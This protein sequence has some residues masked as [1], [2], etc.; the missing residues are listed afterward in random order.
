MAKPDRLKLWQVTRLARIQAFREEEASR[1]LTA[2]RQQLAQA[3][4][5][6]ADAAAAYEKDVAEQAIARHQR[7]Q[8][9]VGRELNGATVRALHA[10]DNAGL[11][12]IKQHAATYKKAGQHTEQA[13]S[14][15]KNAEHA[16]AHARKTT[17][18][19]DKLKLQ[20]QRK[21]RQHERLREEILR[22]E[23]SQML[24]VHRAEDYS[25]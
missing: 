10:E 2:A 21:Y 4:Q 6:M 11:A 8:H 14:V 20:I 15:L 1:E 24:F 9:C 5:Q 25:V 12:S 16:L 23:H 3:R 18:R 17:A 22:D 13:E 19:R 7:W